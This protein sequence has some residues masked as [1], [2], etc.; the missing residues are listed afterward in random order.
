MINFQI[1]MGFLLYCVTPFLAS[2]PDLPGDP[3]SCPKNCDP[4]YLFIYLF[5]AKP[6]S[7]HFHLYQAQ[8]PPPP[9]T[10]VSHVQS[11]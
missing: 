8:D 5:G 2:D 4:R 3:K 11:R 10:T 6:V 1:E 9:P 7:H